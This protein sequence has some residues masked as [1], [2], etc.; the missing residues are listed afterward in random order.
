MHVEGQ[1]CRATLDARTESSTEDHFDRMVQQPL[2]A[3][4]TSEMRVLAESIRSSILTTSPN[5]RWSD[6]AG[7]DS[8]KRLLREAVVHPIMYPHLFTGACSRMPV[9]ESSAAGRC[10][11]PI[12]CSCHLWRASLV[13]LCTPVDGCVRRVHAQGT[14]A[15][16]AHV[17]APQS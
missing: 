7:L 10:A 8:A 5:V 12:N 4:F 17:I 14:A 6:V 13:T 11:C 1:Q 3:H 15:A 16:F 2:P 9:P